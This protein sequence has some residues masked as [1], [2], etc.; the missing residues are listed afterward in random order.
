MKKHTTPILA[1]FLLAACRSSAP[2]PG[3]DAPWRQQLVNSQADLKREVEA[4]KSLVQVRQLEPNR[5]PELSTRLT[6]LGDRMDQLT[7]RLADAGG[8]MVANAAYSPA[9]GTAAASGIQ[10][11]KEGLLVLEQ[12]RAIHC[13]NI[14][15]AGTPG[16]KRR[17]L[18]PITTVDE[19]SG[20][21]VPEPSRPR[22]H[23]QQG[24]LELTG[25]HLD[26]AIEGEGF[27]EVQQ[28]NGE[29]RYRRDGNFRLEY[30]G[31]LVTEEGHLLT[32]QV[33]IPPDVTEISVL[34]DGTVFGHQED[35]APSA[36][37]TIRLHVFSSPSE[38]AAADGNTFAPTISSGQ[39]HAR[40]PG[41]LGT[42]SLRQG[43]LERSNVN[44]TGE[45]VALQIIERQAAAIRLALASQGVYVP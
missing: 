4:L 23:M 2:A 1:V 40:Q 31:R 17:Q 15:N 11:L 35:D 8:A 33:A 32:D 39:S 43:Y 22:L 6:A 5:A 19:T 3:A 27:F 29:L 36:I 41:V 7:A 12:Q 9:P 34:P 28:R 38:L 24:V 26:L 30:N 45:I 21:R 25:N 20:L 42:G 44:I 37:G 14:A 16:H 13:E 18:H 10:A